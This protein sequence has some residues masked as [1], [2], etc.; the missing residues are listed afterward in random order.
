MKLCKKTLE[1]IL[2]FIFW[3]SFCVAV[4]K[5]RSA[6]EDR[7]PT[8]KG[9]RPISEDTIYYFDGAEEKI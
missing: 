4:W 2:I 7:K 8:V 5:I 9:S 6:I 3:M 1:L